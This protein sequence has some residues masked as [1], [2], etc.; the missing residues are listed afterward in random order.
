[1]NRLFTIIL[2][3]AAIGTASARADG[4]P[5][6]GVITSEFV[7]E[8]V[9]MHQLMQMLADFMHYAIADFEPCEEPNSMGDAQGC[10]RGEDTR[11]ANERGVRPNADIS[12]VCAFLCKYGLEAGVELPQGITWEDVRR[13]ARESLVFAYS[14]HK[15]N[16]LTPCVGGRY[17]GSTSANDSQWESS[18]W[19]M[20]VAFSAW[21][22]RE[23]LSSAQWECIYRLLRAE[24]NYELERD[25][26]TGF[27]G[28]T[29]AEENGW[30]TN[31]L[32][33]ALGLFP[34]DPLASQWFQRL[35]EFAINCYSHSS[36]GES[37]QVIDEDIDNTTVADLYRGANLYDDYT[38][39]NHNYFHTSYQN[40]VMQELGESI[41][42]LQLFQQD[43][44]EKP[45]WHTKALLHHQQE[46]MDS[47]LCY[48]ALADGELAM[49]NGNDWSLFLYDQLPS[50]STAAC[51]LRHP[52]ALM[53]ENMA[54]KY[55]A[56]RQQ[57]TAEGS[58]LLHADVGARRMGVQAHRVMM[59][60]LMHH[61]ASTA[62]VRPTQWSQFRKEHSKARWFATQKIVRA[63]TP[64]RFSCFSWSEGLRSYTGY[65]T[66]DT[67]DRNKI[68]VPYR[69][70]GSGNLLGWYEVEGCRTDVRPKGD[71]RVT[72]DGDAWLLEGT[73][74]ANEGAL[75]RRFFVYS[76]P[77][78]ALVVGE[79]V[80]ANKDVTIRATK[81]GALAIS[82]DPF[83][84]E[85]RDVL[86][87]ANWTNVD[88]QV[89][90]IAFSQNS[91]PLPVMADTTLDNSIRTAK[92]YAF[93]SDVPRKVSKGEVVDRRVAV[94]YTQLSARETK[95]YCR[96]MRKKMKKNVL[97]QPFD[98]FDG[99]DVYRLHWTDEG[100]EIKKLRR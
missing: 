65:L 9:M 29:K 8:P 26:P 47:V 37:R 5:V 95:K 32:A 91:R 76:T 20:S 43:R 69:A 6:E 31:V 19:A 16:R 70:F 49:P 63:Y 35:R 33:C 87:K 38:L 4:S 17:W 15:A 100:V 12:M 96:K 85:E 50:Y 64:K 74:L 60:W 86:S 21:L 51:F 78:D 81:G 94:Y 46:V 58:W 27:V 84:K 3:I 98:V 36:D 62:D 88:G 7:E 44:G 34:D 2:F 68:I 24:C 66:S 54:C 73:W 30:E 55:I 14:T 40:V 67:P 57:T 56:A 82:L 93:Y 45:R 83:L 59:T 71:P 72:L 77:D 28:D 75:T 39:Q 42:A 53:L 52:D 10:F 25:I 92:L 1:M 99:R 79:E 18:L 23:S 11:A 80:T 89:A 90:V 97:L 48:L 22:Q 61:L 13:M 41:V